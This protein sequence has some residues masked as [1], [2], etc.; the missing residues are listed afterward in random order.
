MPAT[1]ART[2]S[3]RLFVLFVLAVLS[4]GTLALP[5]R[6]GAA[7]G[8]AP[9]RL[10]VQPPL[11]HPGSAVTVIGQGF[12]ASSAVQVQICGN[13]DL[14]G[15]VDCAVG[16]A[17]EVVA[18]GAGQFQAPLVVAVPPKPCPCVVTALDFSVSSTPE[19][20][21]AVLGARVATPTPVAPRAL[22]IVHA[23]FEGDGPWTS[24]FGG[25]AARTL[26][27][28]VHNPNPVPY[29]QPSF[30]MSF[31]RSVGPRTDEITARTLP[32]VGAAQ[33]RT[34]RIPIT[35]PA[36]S[37]GD[38]HVAAVIG[39]AGLSRRFTVGTRIFPWGLALVLL[40]LAE[41]LLFGLAGIF[42][43]R[44]RR[45]HGSVTSEGSDPTGGLTAGGEEEGRRFEDS[46][47]RELQ[48]AGQTD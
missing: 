17:L 1:W 39:N 43:E 44:Y 25:G 9:P 20:P 38:Q 4:A 47:A 29:I 13:N 8:A 35:F 34:Y 28:T 42:R 18:T 21:I 10:V 46:P 36:F 32:S 24:W 14:D 33:D 16:D 26:V 3:C 45:R 40:V 48:S 22:H 11:Q 27:V 5:A 41:L 31:G 23:S 12:P 30:V 15:S 2:R 19:A 6:A 37:V 7:A